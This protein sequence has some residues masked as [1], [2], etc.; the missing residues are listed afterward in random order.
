[1][2][3]HGTGVGWPGDHWAAAS[4]PPAG[5]VPSIFSSNGR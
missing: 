1:L 5:L 4:G 2:S 3:S